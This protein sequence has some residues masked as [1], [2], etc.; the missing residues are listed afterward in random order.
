MEMLMELTKFFD[1]CGIDDSDLETEGVS[2]DELGL[3]TIVYFPKI[4]VKS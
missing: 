3:D 4:E 1:D 2:C